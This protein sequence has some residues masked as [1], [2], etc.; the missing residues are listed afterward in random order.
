MRKNKIYQIAKQMLALVLTLSL[1]L[2][3]APAMP[4]TTV[5]AASNGLPKEALTATANQTLKSDRIYCVETNIT[6]TGGANQAGLIVGSTAYIYIAKD[7]TL[8]VKGGYAS[9][10]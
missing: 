7:C 8:T 3:L 6:I 5:Q 1:V 9:S 2:G 10:N 4:A